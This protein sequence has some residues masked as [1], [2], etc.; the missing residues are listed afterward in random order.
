MLDA[1]E[2]ERCR[3]DCREQIY[4]CID[5]CPCY[6]DCPNGCTKDCQ[7][8]ICTCLSVKDNQ[9]W[10]RCVDMN[11]SNLGGFSKTRRD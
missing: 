9:Q 3:D 6:K 5:S 10:N 2:S 1:C 4:S 7:S 11:G 8:S